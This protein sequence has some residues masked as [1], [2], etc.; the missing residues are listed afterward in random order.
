MAKGV[1]LFVFGVVLASISQVILKIAANKY[2]NRESFV[3]QYINP[4]VIGAY[5]I[6]F[7]TTVISVIALRWIPLSVAA[8]L[9][10]F[11]QI[12]VPLMSFFIL[13]EP[14]SKNKCIGMTCI[15]IGMVVIMHRPEL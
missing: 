10:A 14:I 9:E 3:L 4:L 1:F 2:S 11:S 6:F 8:I 13:K 7:S 12:F 5:A 15:I